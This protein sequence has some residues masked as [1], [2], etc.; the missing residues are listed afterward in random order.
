MLSSETGNNPRLSYAKKTKFCS[1]KKI[2]NV[3]LST[4]FVLRLKKRTIFLKVLKLFKKTLL[5]LSK[6]MLNIQ[7]PYGNCIFS[8]FLYK[9]VIW[10]IYVEFWDKVI[11]QNK[12]IWKFV[13]TILEKS[14]KFVWVV[15]FHR[16]SLW[17]C[18][19]SVFG[20]WRSTRALVRRPL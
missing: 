10:F 17:N 19:I 5:W 13:D 9:K 7:F 15:F 4:K 14:V 2:G 3:C 11:S 12:T 1:A 16:L 18:M 6:K 20:L 8:I